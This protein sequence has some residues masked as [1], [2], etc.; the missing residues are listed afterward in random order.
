MMKKAVLSISGG[1][2]STTV[3]TWLL[4]NDYEVFP[5]QFQYGSKH[6]EYEA[7]AIKMVMGHYRSEHK[8][9][10]YPGKLNPLQVIDLTGAMAGFTSNLLKTGG[11]I[12]EGHYANANMALTVVPARNIIFLSIAAGLAESL[13]AE[14]IALGIHQGDHDIYPDCRKE[15]FDSMNES[16]KLGTGGKI[17]ILAPFLDTDKAGIVK[18]GIHNGTPYKLTRTCYKD[19]SVPCGR[20]GSCCERRE[21]FAKNK[22]EDP[23]PAED[24]DYFRTIKK[25]TR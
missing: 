13:G 7:R 16:I 24:Q 6:N 3:L 18:Y 8:Q 15:F 5:I 10:P 21:A 19:Q 11:D 9:C 14:A 22:Q 17:S 20:C 12:P 1:L 23:V 25:E 2:D 4:N